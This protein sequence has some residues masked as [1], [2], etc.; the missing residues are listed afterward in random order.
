MGKILAFAGAKQSGKNTCSNFL[1]GTQLKAYGLVDNFYILNNGKLVTESS[2]NNGT[3]LKGILDVTRSDEEFVKWAIEDMWPIVKNYS[4]ADDLKEIGI[5]L[6]KIPREFAYGSDDEKNI[7]LDHL[8]WENMPG[9]LTPD[10][11][12]KLCSDSRACSFSELSKEETDKIQFFSPRSHNPHNETW[13][14]TFEQTGILVHK[15]GPMSTREWLQYFG[16]EICRR[17]YSQIWCD[18]AITKI[19]AEDS[20]L[21]IISDCRFVNECESIKAAG[22]KIIYLN[23]V[24]DKECAHISENDLANYKDFDYVIDNQ[25]LT[26]EETCHS[27]LDAFEKWGWVA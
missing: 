5:T 6:F 18:R 4:F 11:A 26:I 25:N 24:I 20:Q 17:I 10:K 1:H 8:R 14:S 16:S 7:K 3:K 19:K 21:A 13:I 9:V 23:R 2:D 15:P 22:G 27:I 12:W